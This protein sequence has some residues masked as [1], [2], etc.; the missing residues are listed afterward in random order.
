M[1]MRPWTAKCVNAR[2]TMMMP[3]ARRRLWGFQVGEKHSRIT[4]SPITPDLETVRNVVNARRATGA[5][6]RTQPWRAGSKACCTAN[7]SSIASTTL[8]SI[9]SVVV[10]HGRVN[11]PR[12]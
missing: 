12:A 1:V 3:Y 9:G 2:P 5:H 7:G 6:F 4:A 11:P 8:N 10:L